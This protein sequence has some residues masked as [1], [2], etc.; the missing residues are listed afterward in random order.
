MSLTLELSPTQESELQSAAYREGIP[1]PDYAHRL[2]VT[3]L[4]QQTV[5][6]SIPRAK[7]KPATSFDWED[8]LKWAQ[9]QAREALA[10]SGKTDDDIVVDTESEVNAYRAEVHARTQAGR[11]PV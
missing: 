8:D 4:R 5:A 2:F 6:Q 3:A 7:E 11:A 10:A 1:V 9:Q